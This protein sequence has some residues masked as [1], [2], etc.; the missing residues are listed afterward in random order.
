[1]KEKISRMDE[2][3]KAQRNF[4]ERENLTRTAYQ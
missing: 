4:E 3:I 1:V 2:K